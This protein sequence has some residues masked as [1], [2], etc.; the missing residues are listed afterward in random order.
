MDLKFF[1]TESARQF[2]RALILIQVSYREKVAAIQVKFGKFSSVLFTT[3][4]LD[5]EKKMI[6]KATESVGN[7]QLFE[8]GETRN[9]SK[10]F[11]HK[12]KKGQVKRQQYHDE[13]N[14]NISTYQRKCHFIGSNTSESKLYQFSEDTSGSQHTSKGRPLS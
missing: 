9:N 11:Q 10:A 5:L 4:I 12:P 1:W 3:Y 2:G 8:S 14:V 6:R 13:L 7:T